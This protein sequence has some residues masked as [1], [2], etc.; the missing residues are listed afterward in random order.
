MSIFLTGG[1]LDLP[2]DEHP[3]FARSGWQI[4]KVGVDP[5]RFDPIEIRARELTRWHPRT[6]LRSVSKYPYNCVGLVFAARRAW[7]EIDH[8]Y[9]ILREDGYRQI[10]PNQILPGDV[11][12]YHYEGIPTHVALITIVESY[13]ATQ[14]VMVLSKWGADAEFV[15]YVEDVPASM[16]KPV[17]YFTERVS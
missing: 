11:V 5:R 9:D 3:L 1:Y 4:P 16:G 12:L 7:I 13:G 14:N 8:I 15:H 17:E 6:H 10:P 2:D